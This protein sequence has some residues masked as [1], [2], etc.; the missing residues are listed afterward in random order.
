MLLRDPPADPTDRSYSIAER[1]SGGMHHPDTAQREWS[2]RRVLVAGVAAQ[3]I[4]QIGLQRPRTGASLN[5]F[6][7]ISGRGQIF[8]QRLQLQEVCIADLCGVHFDGSAD[9]SPGIPEPPP[10]YDQLRE[11]REAREHLVRVDPLLNVGFRRAE[12]LQVGGQSVWM[13][14]LPYRC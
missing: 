11:W 12:R 1:A 2:P 10:I 6:W 7:G 3:S 5:A 4:S 14:V 13:F 9:F 8:Q